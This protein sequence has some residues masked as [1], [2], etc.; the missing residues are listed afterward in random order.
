MR[1][2]GYTLISRRDRADGRLG[3]GGVAVF[4]LERLARRVT[5]LE[6]S[7]VAERSWVTIHSDHGPYVIGCWYRPPA[8]G[9]VDSI[10]SF[11]EEHSRMLRTQ[12]D[13]FC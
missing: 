3:G 4:A 6:N 8:P 5:L 10:R 2:E 1:I 13:M 7:Q 12:W 9:E 11:T